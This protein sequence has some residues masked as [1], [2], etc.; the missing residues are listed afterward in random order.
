MKKK[1]IIEKLFGFT[2]ATYY[3][4]K[5]E[6]RPIISLIKYFNDEELEE[7]LN[8]GEINSLGFYKSKEK[9]AR[10]KLMQEIESLKKRVSR[11]EDGGA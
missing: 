8:T 3:N 5:K 11:L 10:S 1:E 4:W 2:E 6:N 9:S 7:F